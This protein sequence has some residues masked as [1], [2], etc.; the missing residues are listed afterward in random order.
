MASFEKFLGVWSPWKQKASY[1]FRVSEAE[2]IGA[3]WAYMAFDRDLLGRL[4]VQDACQTQGSF[5]G[6]WGH[7][8][9]RWG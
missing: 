4:A 3:A 9:I 2:R 7:G 8:L 1:S 5:E 6:L